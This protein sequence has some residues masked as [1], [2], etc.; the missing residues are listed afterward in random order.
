MAFIYIQGRVTLESYKRIASAYEEPTVFIF[1]GNASHHK[2]GT[3]LYSVKTGGGLAAAAGQIGTAGYPVLS[4]PTTGMESWSTN[5]LIKQTV[6]NAIAD[7]YRAIGAGYHIMLPVR[8]FEN[9]FF[10]SA[11]EIPDS[12]P[13]EPSFWG[14]F[15]TTKNPGLAQYYIDELNELIKFAALDH[16]ARLTKLQQDNPFHQAYLAGKAMQK[17]DPWLA[18]GHSTLGRSDAEKPLSKQAHVPPESK[19]PLSASIIF[20]FFTTLGAGALVTVIVL[21]ALSMNPL[22]LGVVAGLG[23]VALLVGGL[24]LFF[25]RPQPASRLASDKDSNLKPGT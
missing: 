22:I 1:P 20:G 6:S 3:T 16:E 17:T 10:A 23:A 24:G 7:V 12:P 5:P 4:L 13:L 19:R 18:H 25:T 21:A 14:L 15:N 11:L 2:P 9:N 8:T